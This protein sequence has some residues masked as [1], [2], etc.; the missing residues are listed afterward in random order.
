MNRRRDK[1]VLNFGLNLQTKPTF[2]PKVWS[3]D[4]DRCIYNVILLL[5]GVN[6]ASRSN[7]EITETEG[8]HMWMIN[9]TFVNHR[10]DKNMEKYNAD[11]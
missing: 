5:L 4:R 11:N 3:L 8:D 7:L 2:Y 10:P 9:K 1:L 6:K